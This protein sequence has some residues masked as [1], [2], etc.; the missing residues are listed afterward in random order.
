MK[1]LRV[2]IDGPKSIEENM[3]IDEAIFLAKIGTD[4]TTSTLRFYE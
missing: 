2:I 3:A 4:N 1:N